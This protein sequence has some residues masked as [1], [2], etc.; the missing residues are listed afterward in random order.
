MTAIHY[1]LWKE[2]VKIMV[3]NGSNEM[4]EKEG[5]CKKRKAASL[6]GKGEC[7][8]QFVRKYRNLI[9]KTRFTGEDVTRRK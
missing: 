5:N 1:V 8:V 2:R 4:Q 7:G 6:L 3:E 9:V